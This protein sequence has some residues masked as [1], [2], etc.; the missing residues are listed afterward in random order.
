MTGNVDL[1][2]YLIGKGANPEITDAGGRKAID[3]VSGAQGAASRAAT[4]LRS[5]L[6]NAVAKK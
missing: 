6:E 1:A 5:L 4:E 2:R 3:L